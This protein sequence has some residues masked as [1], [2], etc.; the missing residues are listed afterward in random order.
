MNQFTSFCIPTTN[1][2]LFASEP[3][4]IFDNT[5]NIFNTNNINNNDSIH[6][7]L[8]VINTN[9]MNHNLNQI[10]NNDMNKYIKQKPISQQMEHVHYFKCINEDF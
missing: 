3:N 8:N 9:S 7:A 6:N 2:Q 10:Q 5:I 1:S 4:T